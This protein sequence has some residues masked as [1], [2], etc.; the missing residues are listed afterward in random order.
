[1]LLLLAGM[2]NSPIICQTGFD[3]QWDLDDIICKEQERAEASISNRRFNNAFAGQTDI[4]YEVISWSIDPAER[5]IA[6]E[7][8]YYFKSKVQDLT[9]LHLDLNKVMQ[10]NAIKRD[11]DPLAYTHGDDNL[12]VINLGKTLQPDETD[13]L[14]I[15]YEGVPQ[16]S[17]FG[18]FEQGEHAGQPI[19]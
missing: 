19:L 12:L 3:V 10:I 13:H 6:G 18:S 4:Y 14:T 15:V 8:T 7:I 9:L 2:Y 1:M 5:Y 17:G 16:T 11:G